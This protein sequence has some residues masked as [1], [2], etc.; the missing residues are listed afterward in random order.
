M[1]QIIYKDYS[2]LSV[3]T[4]EM[5]AA[6]IIKKP[7]ALLCFPAG[8]TSIGTFKILIDLNKSGKLSFK[9]CRIVGLD[10]W[11][12][13]GEMKSENGFSFMRKHLFD[14]I[15][16]PKE[17]LL[18]FDGESAD[19]MNECKKTDDFIR[20]YGPV[21]MMLLG[22]GMNGHLGLNEPGTSFGLN[23]HIAQ[24]DETTKAVGK[25]YFSAN[26]ELSSGITLGIKDIMEA[27]TVILQINGSRKANITKKLFE[28][29]V[30]NAFPASVLKE[31]KN[32]FI[33][34]DR[35]AASLL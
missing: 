7:D 6:T 35:E 28:S 30:T 34:L 27:K 1:K 18:F 24:L 10:E 23:A 15:D 9:K 26:V 33:L 5:I 16:Y 4:A 25:K 17:N 31:H 12:H 20:K 13:I 14:H 2:E 3:K 21:D 29:E 19:L 22:I 32:S 11:A 8:E